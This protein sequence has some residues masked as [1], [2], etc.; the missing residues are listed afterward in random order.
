MAWKITFGIVVFGA[1]AFAAMS[2]IPTTREGG[3]S[4]EIKAAPEQIVAVLRDARGQK[5]WRSDIK[6]IILIGDEWIE[7]NS[8]GEEIVFRWT[9]LAPERAEL[10]FSSRAGYSGTWIST[11]SAIAHGTRMEVVER[12]TIPNPIS[13][14]IARIFF[15]PA[16]FSQSYLSQ[17]KTRVEG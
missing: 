16:A 11:L 14:L 3:A 17:L 7:V 9:I 4:I 10:E 8:W 6:D 1:I 13:R 2:L 12:T 5:S 15:D